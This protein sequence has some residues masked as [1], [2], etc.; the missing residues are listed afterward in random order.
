MCVQRLAN[1]AKGW[2]PCCLG[3]VVSHVQVVVLIGLEPQAS[4]PK[5]VNVH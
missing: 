5:N 4:A 3:F 2:P 1:A